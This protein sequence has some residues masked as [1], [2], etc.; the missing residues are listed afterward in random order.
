MIMKKE[1]IT[2]ICDIVGNSKSSNWSDIMSGGDWNDV[3]EEVEAEHFVGRE[4]ELESFRQ[5]ISPVNPRYLI[6]YITGQAGAGKTTLLTRYKGI[7]EEY[8][9]LLS[10]SNEQ[11]RD[12]PTVL[13]R[14]AQQLTDQGFSFKN[15][16]ERYKTYRQ[17]MHEIE[18]DPEAPQGF[19]AT[20][21]RT[22]V[23]AAFIGG[24]AVP[25]V[26]KGL[27]Y[28]PREAVEAQASEWVTYL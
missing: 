22:V 17:K 8:D 21:A 5:H 16:D 25:G 14:F 6:F 4:Q 12:V 23:R 7:A 15:F 27:E 11:Q 19:A 13:G 3:Y 20:L 18:N 1:K 26:R 10:D 2:L 9:F 24:D 28:I